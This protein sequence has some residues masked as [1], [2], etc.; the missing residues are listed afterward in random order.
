MA[1]IKDE[2]SFGSLYFLKHFAYQTKGI[3]QNIRNKK[4][5]YRELDTELDIFPH[6]KFN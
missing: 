6:L 2:N 4:P 1:W 5:R 3:K